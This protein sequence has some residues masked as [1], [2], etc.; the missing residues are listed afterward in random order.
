MSHTIIN[1]IC[2]VKQ[3]YNPRVRKYV[4]RLGMLRS[5]I[6]Q[7]KRLSLQ[8]RPPYLPTAAAVTRG[9]VLL[10][11]CLTRRCKAKPCLPS[12]TGRPTHI[13]AYQ[14]IVPRDRCLYFL[15]VHCS[16][17]TAP[18]SLCVAIGSLVECLRIAVYLCLLSAGEVSSTQHWLIV[19]PSIV[20]DVVGVLR[21][22]GLPQSAK[23]EYGGQRSL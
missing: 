9:A 16:P 11:R 6:W 7:P 15:S 17:P 2:C 3:P 22:S 8:L 5:E 21:L 20:H 4:A 23:E 19:S 18:A 14:L 1:I 10:P 13:P 12:P